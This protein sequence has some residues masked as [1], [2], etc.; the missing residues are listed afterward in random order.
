MKLFIRLSILVVCL[1][2]GVVSGRGA[3]MT[4]ADVIKMVD[5]KLD[6]SIII[7]AIENADAKFDVSTQGLIALTASKV[8]AKVVQAMIKR[9]SSPA[10]PVTEGTAATDAM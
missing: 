1:C 7:T 9:T 5:A 8:P 3:Q 6:D 4:K 10:T 2:L